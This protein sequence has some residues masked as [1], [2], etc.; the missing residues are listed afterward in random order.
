MYDSRSEG[1]GRRPRPSFL[2]FFILALVVATIAF[3]ISKL[4][5]SGSRDELRPVTP[6]GDLADWEK[7][8]IQIFENAAPSVVGVT[9]NKLIRTR[10]LWVVSTEEVPQGAGTG[11]VWNDQGH[12]VTN[13]HV[14]AGGENFVVQFYGMREPV[15]AIVVGAAKQYDLAVLKVEVPAAK[16]RPIPVG[17]SE[18]L[19][20]GQAVLAIGSPFGLDHTLTTGVVS[21]LGRN[22]R[23]GENG[24]VIENVIQTDAAIN[25]GNSGGPLL[26]SAGRL[27]GVN[28]GIYS[29]VKQSAGIGFSI[30]IDTVNWVVAELIAEGRIVR[31]YL[32]IHGMSTT[33]R[34]FQYLDL[35]KGILVTQTVAKG[36]AERA[37]IQGSAQRGHALAGDIIYAIGDQRIV[38]M[39]DLQAALEKYRNGDDVDV[40]YIRDGK[41]YLVKVRL[42]AARNP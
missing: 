26:D 41:S 33:E 34:R 31:P 16:L 37:G 39:G 36:P 7:T 14:L 1:F 40:K 10:N 38:T 35:K 5:S 19:K 28:S 42:Q 11:I 32:G 25:P 4:I 13:H 17:K 30:P 9:S 22:L 27:I 21:A 20:V 24:R 15:E 6:R 29:E 2:N 3:G 18:N 12:I 8:T 23:S